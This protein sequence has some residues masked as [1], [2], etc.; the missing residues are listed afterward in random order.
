MKLCIL[1]GGL[2]GFSTAAILSKYA[3]DLEIKLIH[4]PSKQ[5]LAV[6][7][8]T[9]LPI[10]NLFQFLDIKESEWM[11]ECDATYKLGVRFQ[12][13][14]FG[15]H[16]F[17]PFGKSHVDTNEWFI[18]KDL[19]NLTPDQSAFFFN[20]DQAALLHY[21]K[22]RDDVTHSYHF[23]ATKLSNYLEN[24][25]RKNGV[26][27]VK[28]N[29]RDTIQDERGTIRALLCDEGTH[30]ADYFVDCT[31][32]KA[33]LIGNAMGAEWISYDKTLLNDTVFKAEIPYKDK[34]TELKNYTDSV[35]LKNGWCFD[36]PLWSHRSVGYVHSSNFDTS[37]VIQDEFFKLY[38]E[39][40]YQEIRFK[41]GRHR[42]GWINNVIAVGASY[43]FTEPLE[44]TN[45]SATLNSIFALAEAL[46]KR[47][48][49]VTQV[50]RDMYN[51]RNAETLDKFRFFVE[52]HYILSLRDD[53]NYWRHI[54][55]D[56]NW[57][58][59]TASD[60]NY[61]NFLKEVYEKRRY[62][63]EDVSALAVAAGQDYS[64]LSKDKIANFQFKIDNFYR[65]VNNFIDHASKEP[66]SYQYLNQ[67]IYYEN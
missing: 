64:C 6:G 10:Q 62:G 13:F 38:G 48:L 12:D 57:D 20:P 31:G 47:N 59:Q 61:R 36:I 53:S 66:T 22:I 65:D 9:Q 43:G 67:H 27:I 26:E 11:K 32:F 16:Y 55:D 34:D 44:A 50:D 33:L 19:C 51:V 1:G 7:E 3:S 14:N 5:A 25:A 40:D 54:A 63:H 18:A 39:L 24:F 49:R 42:E 4:N 56:I 37:K 58:Y 30:F 45:I 52:Q 60:F 8:S 23:N 46:S 17:N 41:T 29:Y 2:A 35:A 21:N 15:T 28:D